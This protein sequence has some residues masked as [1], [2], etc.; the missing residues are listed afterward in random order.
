MC[1]DGGK[2]KTLGSGR[3]W[4]HSGASGKPEEPELLRTWG[5]RRRG[6]RQGQPSG[7]KGEGKDMMEGQHCLG[8][9]GSAEEKGHE[10]G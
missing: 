7:G 6:R 5:P 10:Q 1:F 3:I 9:T 2:C 8:L 4:I